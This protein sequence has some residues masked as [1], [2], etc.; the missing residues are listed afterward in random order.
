MAA[1]AAADRRHRVQN[2]P[3]EHPAAAAETAVAAG[4]RFGVVA[5]VLLAAA[6]AAAGLPA[7]PATRSA[8]RAC[9]GV[10]RTIRE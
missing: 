10:I 4:G 6:A 1:V 8:A 9:I 5:L 3:D 7:K 2:R